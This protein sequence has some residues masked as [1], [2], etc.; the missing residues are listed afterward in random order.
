MT[1]LSGRAAA[2]RVV[3]IGGLSARGLGGKIR[4]VQRPV[5]GEPSSRLVVGI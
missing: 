1:S 4:V 2:T 5:G 3:R